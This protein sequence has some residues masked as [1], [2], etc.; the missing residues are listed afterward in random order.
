MFFEQEHTYIS[1]LLGLHGRP[2]YTTR[3]LKVETRIRIINSCKLHCWFSCALP[4]DKAKHSLI[5]NHTRLRT[6]Y[7]NQK[8]SPQFGRT[9]IYGYV[10][11]C[12]GE[13]REREVRERDM[14]VI[15]L[16]ITHLSVCNQGSV[17]KLIVVHL[18]FDLCRSSNARQ[19]S[20]LVR[21]R[22]YDSTVIYAQI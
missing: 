1:F 12:L 18:L 3:E 11:R 14:I 22:S 4:Y 2:F 9:L 21:T 10:L 13:E 16:D 17:S 5:E 15:S 7:I 19:S 20:L 8:M 6:F